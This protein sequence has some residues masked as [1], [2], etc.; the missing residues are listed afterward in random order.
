MNITPAPTFQ[1]VFRFRLLLFT[2]SRII[3]NILLLNVTGRARC[4]NMQNT[5][6]FSDS[7]DA[8]QNV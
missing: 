7:S 2:S 5:M 4:F 3:L 6:F 1:P 8:S